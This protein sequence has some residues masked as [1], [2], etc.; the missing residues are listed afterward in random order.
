MKKIFFVLTVAL[1]LLNSGCGTLFFH[2]RMGKKMS[3]VVDKRVFVGNCIFGLF[4]IIPGVVAFILDYNSETIYYTEA[5]LIPDDF[6]DQ[7]SSLQMRQIPCKGMTEEEIS[8]RLSAALGKEISRS[9]LQ[10][11]LKR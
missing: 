1:L 8:R 6:M 11:A 7:K 9:Q 2:D 4:G 5:E 10:L 3:K